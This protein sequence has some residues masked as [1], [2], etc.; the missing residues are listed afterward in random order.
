MR[1]SAPAKLNLCLD[2]LKKSPNGYHKIQTILYEL[3]KFADKLEILS[4]Q[5]PDNTSIAQGGQKPDE[6]T[7]EQI[8]FLNQN[9]QKNLAHQALLLIKKTFKIRK[10]AQIKITKNIPFNSGL[11]G[12]ASDAAAVLKGLNKLWKLNMDQKILL[13]LAEKLGKDVPFFI[14][15]GTALATNYGEKIKPLNSLKNLKFKIFPRSS[16]NLQ[17]TKDNFAALDLKKCAQDLNQTKTLLKAI[18]EN[19]PDEI[20][21][22]LHN[23]FSQLY[24]LK[25]GHYLSGAGPSTFTVTSQN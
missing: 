10:N 22:N 15:G 13:K 16:K 11:G 25:K 24:T 9:P 3:P 8:K 20:L 12:G 2:V 7:V 5:K 4:T 18:K 21:T 6:A 17:K 1:I 23:D 14:I 19:N